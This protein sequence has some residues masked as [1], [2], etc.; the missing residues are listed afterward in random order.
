M[1]RL[2]KVTLLAVS[3]I[4]TLNAVSGLAPSALGSWSSGIDLQRYTIQQTGHLGPKFLNPTQ[5]TWF[6]QAS[7]DPVYG[8]FFGFYTILGGTK[9]ERQSLEYL[10]ALSPSLFL[11][12]GVAL[13]SARMFARSAAGQKRKVVGL[14]SPLLFL[15]PF[16]RLHVIVLG[17]A[18]NALAPAIVLLVLWLLLRELTSATRNPRLTAILL[19]MTFVLMNTYHTWATYFA[20]LAAVV[21]LWIGLRR[22][23]LRAVR[24]FYS[25]ILSL[26]PIF[27]LATALYTSDVALYARFVDA[28]TV[29]R[30]TSSLERPIGFYFSSTPGPLQA[31]LRVEPILSYGH[32]SSLVALALFSL[33]L[34]ISSIVLKRHLSNVADQPFAEI[35]RAHV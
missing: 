33:L 18:G 24:G 14:V 26:V 20:I 13:V 9:D 28:V 7:G 3:W 22:G 21:S 25:R 11:Y 27:W 31:Y 2:I 23:F 34:A 12:A 32:L 30:T 16:G 1:D 29:L 10:D 15:V 8:L 35:G 19:V 4:L 5:A 17:Y 6:Q